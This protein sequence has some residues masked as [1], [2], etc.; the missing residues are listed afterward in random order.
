MPIRTT[1]LILEWVRWMNIRPVLQTKA[2]R[3]FLFALFAILPLTTWGGTLKKMDAAALPGDM[4]ELRLMF[5]GP[6]P[7]AKGYSIEQ[8]P[9][10][11]LDLPYTRSDL[12]KYNEIGF[13]NARSVTVLEAGDRTRLVN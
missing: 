11:S 6:A 9:R 5:D 7:T 4:V 2:V 10:I 13:D 1:I 12:P 3:S 8:P